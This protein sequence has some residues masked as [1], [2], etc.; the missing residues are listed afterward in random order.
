MLPTCPFTVTLTVGP[1]RL[2]FAKSFESLA[3]ASTYAEASQ[4]MS[5]IRRVVIDR[6]L[7]DWP[8]EVLDEEAVHLN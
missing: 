1:K 8:A 3:A 5:G 6:R 7:S 2:E 4:R